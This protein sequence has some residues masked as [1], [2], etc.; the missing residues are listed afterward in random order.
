MSFSSLLL[1]QSSFFLGRPRGSANSRQH[2][3]PPG[4]LFGIMIINLMN[5]M[6]MMVIMIIM[7]NHIDQDY[8]EHDDDAHDEDDN[9]SDDH[10]NFQAIILS[11]ACGSGKTYASMV[12]LR[13]VCF[14]IIILSFLIIITIIMIKIM[15]ITINII[16]NTC[17]YLTSREEDQRQTHSNIS[18]LLSLSFGKSLLR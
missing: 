15:K 14:I 11:G 16:T 8:N 13:Q 3:L 12:L 1:F 17:S 9:D 7:M 6:I 4:D 18:P 2:R 5:M 10:E